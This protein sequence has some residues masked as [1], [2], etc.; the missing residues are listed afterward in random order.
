MNY[1][2]KVNS[3]K[4]MDSKKKVKFDKTIVIPVEKQMWKS[5]RQISFD[6][7]ISMSKLARKAIQKI[8]NKYEKRID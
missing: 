6:Q 7:N 5:L 2:Y 8:I 1:Q 4:K 3:E